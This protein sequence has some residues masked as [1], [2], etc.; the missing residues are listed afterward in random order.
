MAIPI[1]PVLWFMGGLALVQVISICQ[2]IFFADCELQTFY[3]DSNHCKNKIII[4][5]YRKN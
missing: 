5:I 3:F 1:G 4:F 2:I